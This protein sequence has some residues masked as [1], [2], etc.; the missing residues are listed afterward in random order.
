MKLKIE[1]KLL[2]RIKLENRSVAL[3]TL[4]GMG[5][6]TIL[7]SMCV[8]NIGLF[9]ELKLEL[10]ISLW[11]RE[12]KQRTSNKRF[13]LHAAIISVIKQHFS[14]NSPSESDL[15]K[16]NL[17]NFFNTESLLSVYDPIYIVI[18][19]FQ[20]LPY[21]LAVIIL[22]EIKRLDDHR[23]DAT[24][25]SIK[26]VKFLIGG[27]FD[28]QILYKDRKR[29]DSPATNFSK[30]RPYEF[31][32]TEIEIKE[33]I[34]ENCRN[35]RT[36]EVQFVTEWTNGYLHYVI[37]FCDW[38]QSQKKDYGSNCSIQQL[39]LKLR[40]SLEEGEAK[41]LFSYCCSG[42]KKFKDDEDALLLLGKATS[43]GY[44]STTSDKAKE[45]TCLGLLMQKQSQPDMYHFPN[46][47]IEL[48]VR[49]K[50]AEKN[51]VLPIGESACWIVK[52][53]N[54]K[55]YTQLLE[56][57]NRL[58]NFIGDVIYKSCGCVMVDEVVEKIKDSLNQNDPEHKRGTKWKDDV[59]YKKNS[60]ARSPFS[61]GDTFDSI[62]TYLDFADLGDI[63]SV[64]ERNFSTNFVSMLPTFLEEL[65]YI[66]RRIAHNRPITE[67]Q[68]GDMISRWVKIQRMMSN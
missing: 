17:P 52:G 61:S 40:E 62:L 33:Y 63:I 23:D 25:G 58:R 21:D 32:L 1:E 16:T 39:I 14:L 68:L 44:V 3:V 55:A 31:F 29:E 2:E 11:E 43:A 8:Q 36:D 4:P 48:F 49:Q 54:I 50:L 57:E 53:Q 42:W 38:I 37:S 26:S 34:E 59:A 15:Y 60:E 9:L 51:K 24:N 67:T 18:D 46:Q 47:I 56:I 30:H 66:R 35:F 45:L 7:H 5:L 64:T 20:S 41:N 65:N 22:D 28:F 13:V 27:A 12:Y 19:D 6:S 10:I